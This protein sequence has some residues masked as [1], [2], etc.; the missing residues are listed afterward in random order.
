MMR[1]QNDRGCGLAAGFS[2]KS[3]RE[4]FIKMIS[5][6]GV[7]EDTGVRFGARLKRTRDSVADYSTLS[8]TKSRH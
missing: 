3:Q 4:A 5:R 1:M 2:S 8:T 6:A 7:V